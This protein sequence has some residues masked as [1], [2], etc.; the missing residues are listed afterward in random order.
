MKTVEYS[1]FIT[2]C[3]YTFSNVNGKE[4]PDLYFLLSINLQKIHA[5]KILVITRMLST[6]I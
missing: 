4:K 1:F 3:C 5:F 6:K 2:N